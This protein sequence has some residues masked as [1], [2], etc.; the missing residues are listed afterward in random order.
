MRHTP[1]VGDHA[2]WHA[3][4]LPGP[5]RLSE[6]GISRA[7]GPGQAASSGQPWYASMSHRPSLLDRTHV[8]R[9]RRDAGAPAPAGKTVVLSVMAMAVLSRRCR[10]LRTWWMRREPF[11]GPAKAAAMLVGMTSLPGGEKPGR[12][13]GASPASPATNASVSPSP[14][15]LDTSSNTAWMAVSGP[16]RTADVSLLVMISPGVSFRQ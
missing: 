5:S 8:A 6:A 12:I 1:R 15:A 4:V 11:S 2:C 7:P 9:S 10:M 16:A 13:A 3:L 14:H